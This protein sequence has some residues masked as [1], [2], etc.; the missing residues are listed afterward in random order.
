[1]TTDFREKTWFKLLDKEGNS[2][3]GGT[4]KWSLPNVVPGE[5][6]EVKGKI[7]CCS[8]GLHFTCE[9]AKWV[10]KDCRFFIAEID[11]SESDFKNDE[12]DNKICVRKGRLIR[13]ATSDDLITS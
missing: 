10:Q 12:S 6:H 7:K 11:F 5:W 1:M 4:M 2:I 3:H 13:E 9:P 8:N